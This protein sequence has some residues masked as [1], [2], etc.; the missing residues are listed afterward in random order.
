MMR[1]QVRDTVDMPTRCTTIHRGTRFR[2][3]AG[4][5]TILGIVAFAVL[6]PFTT[7][8]LHIGYGVGGG[9]RAGEARAAKSVAAHGAV[10]PYHGSTGDSICYVIHVSVDG[11]RPD[12]V[13]GLGA[14][15]APNFFRMRVAGVFT[16]NARTDYDLTSTLPNHVC[17]L[18]GR[19]VSGTAGHNVSFNDDN[20]GTLEEAHGSYVAGVFDVVHDHGLRT[21]MYASKGKFAFLERSWDDANGAPDTVGADDGRDKI[22]IYLNMSDTDALVDSFLAHT[23]AAPQHYSFI[24]LMDPDAVGH[25]SGWN[26]G[27]YY[28]TVIEM[29]GL[30]GRIFDFLDTAAVFTGRTAVIVTADHGGSGTGHGDP[31]VPQNYTVPLYIFGPG[32]PAGADCYRLNGTSRG[33]PATGRPYQTVVPQP[34][35]NGDAANLALD[36]LGLP[37]ITGSVIN[38]AQDLA[39]RPAPGGGKLPYVAILNPEDGSI[40]EIIASVQIEVTAAVD[41]GSITAVEFF[42]DWEKLGEDDT[43]PYTHTW[44][45]VPLGDHRIA[46]RAWTDDSL[47]STARIDIEV[48][49]MAGVDDTRRRA[50]SSVYPNPFAHTARVEFI[51]PR[52][53]RIEMEVFDLLG[54]RMDVHFDRWYG[55][56]RHVENIDCRHLAPGV[57]FYYL[58]GRDT[59]SAKEECASSGKFMILR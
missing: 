11:L 5:V 22:D 3:A 20:G 28:D 36:L 32:I 54:R 57:Y 42:S 55:G 41:G 59:V 8:S 38:A 21:G 46:A 30:I 40:F 27:P 51:L 35:R 45:Q 29:D 34:I 6:I 14:A 56:G 52:E 58:R 13:S 16:D 23:E 43:P 25:A 17:Q 19:H 15:N 9:L 7:V 18:T 31:A 44:S 2:A 26:S 39:I 47:A 33:D 4:P 37:A 24:H 12:A 50:P 10:P 53:A 48:T 1:A 49:S